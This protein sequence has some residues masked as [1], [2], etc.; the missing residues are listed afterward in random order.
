MVALTRSEGTLVI[1]AL[2]LM[3]VLY[4]RNR[5][6]LRSGVLVALPILAFQILRVLR[7]SA[8]FTS[9]VQGSGPSS[10]FVRICVSPVS[11][12]LHASILLDD[13]VPDQD[14]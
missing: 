7:Y 13:H 14:R 10:R 5:E 2:L 9:P 1:L 4:Y 6:S 8:V 3:D 12:L 11:H